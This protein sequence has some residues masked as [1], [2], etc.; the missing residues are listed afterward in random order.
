MPEYQNL[1][2]TL[3]EK[4]VDVDRIIELLKAFFGLS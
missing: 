1:L 4:G 2:E 3:R